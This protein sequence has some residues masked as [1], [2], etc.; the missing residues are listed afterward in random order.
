MGLTISVGTMAS[1]EEVVAATEEARN[2]ARQNPIEVVQETP[3][4]VR[5]AREL[6][7]YE[8]LD[9]LAAKASLRYIV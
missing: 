8:K 6:Q 3:E 7:M 5:I 1:K 2:E 4:Q 9:E